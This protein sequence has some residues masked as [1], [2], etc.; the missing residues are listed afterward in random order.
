MIFYSTVSITESVNPMSLH[1]L[2]WLGV[3]YIGFSDKKSLCDMSLS[4]QFYARKLNPLPFSHQSPATYAESLCRIDVD[5]FL[6][7]SGKLNV[8]F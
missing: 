6:Y 8:Q 3:N 2:V 7:A 4:Y 1:H 5:A